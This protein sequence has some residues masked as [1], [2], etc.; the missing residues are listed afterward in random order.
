MKA[1]V[2]VGRVWR[3]LSLGSLLGSWLLLAGCEQEG[4]YLQMEEFLTKSDEGERYMGGSCMSGS[5]GGG[6]GAGRA[7]GP[8][9]NTA[10]TFEYSYQSGEGGVHFVFKNGL[11]EILAERRYNEK[12]LSSGQRDEVVVEFGEET[13]RFV[14]WGVQECQPIREPEGD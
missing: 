4:P 10:D 13:Y 7:P 9:G 14:H 1:E 6:V 3:C 11:G 8:D 12:F 5:E 2:A